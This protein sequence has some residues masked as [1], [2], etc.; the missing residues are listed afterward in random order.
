MACHAP[1]RQHFVEYLLFPL[2][3][4]DAFFKHQQNDSTANIKHLCYFRL[5]YI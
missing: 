2:A 3:F 4:F 5:F 1:T